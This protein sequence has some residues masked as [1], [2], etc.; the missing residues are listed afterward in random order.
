MRTE[1]RSSLVSS[2]FITLKRRGPKAFNAFIK[3]IFLFKI[4]TYYYDEYSCVK[5]NPIIV[6]IGLYRNLD[7]EMFSYQIFYTNITLVCGN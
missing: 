5:G 2:F 7:V 1:T 3:G 6:V 4:V